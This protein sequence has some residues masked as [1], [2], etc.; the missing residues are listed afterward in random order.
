M[1][2][3]SP[4]DKTLNIPSIETDSDKNKLNDSSTNIS[5]RLDENNEND[6]EG[7]EEGE[8][9]EGDIEKKNKKKGF[10]SLFSSNK[11]KNENNEKLEKALFPK[12]KSQVNARGY[13]VNDE[14]LVLGLSLL[15]NKHL[16]GGGASGSG[17]GGGVGTMQGISDKAKGAKRQLQVAWAKVGRNVPVFEGLRPLTLLLLLLSF[18]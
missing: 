16:Y 3:F 2:D 11:S 10:F 14:R 4:T 9:K 1:N 8:E 13:V 7:G 18:V 12:Y 15:I 5:R 6:E 17:S